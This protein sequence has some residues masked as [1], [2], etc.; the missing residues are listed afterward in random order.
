MADWLVSHHREAEAKRLLEQL[1]ERQPRSVEAETALATL[2]ERTGHVSV[3]Q[4]RYEKILGEHPRAAA[5]SYHLA[6]LYLDRGNLETALELAVSAKGLLPDDAAVSSLLGRIY[7]KRRL[8]GHAVAH[9]EDAV[10]AA[11]ANADYRYQLGSAYVS[12]GNLK[13]ARGELTRALQIDQNFAQ[14]AETR[15]LLASLH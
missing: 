12:A 14:A 2:L 6:A 15:A 3:A 10:R 9:L 11:P 1:I 8:P 4:A 13:A 7:M 5:A